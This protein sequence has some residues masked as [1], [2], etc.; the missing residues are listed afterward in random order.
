MII[1]SATKNVDKFQEKRNSTGSHL[2][3]KMSL[4]KRSR[5][6]G[7]GRRLAVPIYYNVTAAAAFLTY[8]NH[9]VL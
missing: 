6:S 8:N 2:Q 7:Q 9:R 1:L 4:G 5:E 3:N